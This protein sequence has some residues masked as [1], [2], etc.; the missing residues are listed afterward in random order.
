MRKSKPAAP[1]CTTGVICTRKTSGEQCRK[2]F[3]DEVE[4][5]GHIALEHTKLKKKKRRPQPRDRIRKPSAAER[6]DIRKAINEAPSRQRRP[7]PTIMNILTTQR[8]K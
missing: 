6:R 3:P 8:F 1:T 5:L 2:W 7:S 4:L